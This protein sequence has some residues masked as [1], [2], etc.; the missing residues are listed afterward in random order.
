MNEYAKQLEALL[1]TAGEAVEKSELLELLKIESDVLSSATAEISSHLGESGLSLIETDTHIELVTSPAVAEFL[2]S[3]NQEDTGEL[4]AAAAETLS[5]IA[6][7]GPISRYDIDM[8]RGVDSRRMI[9]GL[10][11]RGVVQRLKQAGRT[12]LYDITEE[13]LKQLG[14]E[15]KTQLPK[16]TELNSNEAV[17]KLL[18]KQ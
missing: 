17:T 15:N 3:F 11:A 7:R 6:Y 4:S 5:I 16:Y 8:I 18:A 10:L 14:F 9:R 13:F 1:F 12:P 2:A